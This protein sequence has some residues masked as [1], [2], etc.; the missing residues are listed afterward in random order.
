MPTKVIVPNYFFVIA[1]DKVIEPILWSLKLDETFRENYDTD[2]SLMWQY[3]ASTS[4]FLR[5]FPG[6]YEYHL[7]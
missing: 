1:G 5:H 3:F 6:T 2:P 4:G 7:I